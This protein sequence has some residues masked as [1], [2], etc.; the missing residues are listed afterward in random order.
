M[1]SEGEEDEQVL[2]RK[3]VAAVVWEASSW[4]DEQWVAVPARAAQPQS[5]RTLRSPLRCLWRRAPEPCSKTPRQT[6][7]C[8]WGTG[9]MRHP[10]TP[11]STTAEVQGVG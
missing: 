1:V 7:C 6:P 5:S 4:S 11:H 2:A 10:M 9:I 3:W 8:S